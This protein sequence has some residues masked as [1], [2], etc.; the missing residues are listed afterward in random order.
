MNDFMSQYKKLKVRF[1]SF[2]KAINLAI[3][4]NVKIIVETGTAREPD[5]WHGDGL[6]TILFGHFCQTFDSRLWTCDIEG[7][8][9]EMSRKLSQEYAD[10]ITYVV[11]DSVTFLHNFEGKIDFLYLDS[12]DSKLEQMEASQQHNLNEL[13]ASED[14][15]HEGTIILI[16]DYYPQRHGK[17]GLSVP[18]LQDKGW[19]LVTDESQAL[20]IKD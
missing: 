3:E 8:H 12:F 17:G 19:K 13:K 1:N 18:Y 9:I 2:S 7:E 10:R 6:S 16:D 11:G 15:I 4:R 20:L 5:N 14:K